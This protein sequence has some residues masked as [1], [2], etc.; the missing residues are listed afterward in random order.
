VVARDEA[1]A[2]LRLAPALAHARGRL[3]G[4]VRLVPGLI[5]LHVAA[6]AA[7][8]LLHGARVRAHSRRAARLRRALHPGGVVERDEDLELGPARG[9]E[10]GVDARALHG[11]V[12]RVPGDDVARPLDLEGP[13]E[14]IAE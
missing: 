7:M 12:D 3:R 11:V 6:P 9:G 10:P 13:E 4:R 5:G 14:R 8:E 2:L 1:S